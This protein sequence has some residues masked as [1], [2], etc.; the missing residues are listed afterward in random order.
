MKRQIVAATYN[1]Y[2]NSA[3]RKASPEALKRDTK[4]EKELQL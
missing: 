4:A 2:I 3:E 1:N